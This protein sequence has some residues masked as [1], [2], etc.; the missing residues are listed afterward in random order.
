MASIYQSKSKVYWLIRNVPSNLKGN[1][2]SKNR[3]IS[4]KT[5]RYSKMIALHKLYFTV[6]LSA[7]NTGT[8][9]RNTAEVMIVDGNRTIV[10]YKLR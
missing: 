10:S 4:C 9:V 8:F 2:I 1:F 3:E 5:G 7:Q 6:T